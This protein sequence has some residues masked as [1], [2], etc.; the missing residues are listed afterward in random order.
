MTTFTTEDRLA[1]E[2][3]PQV[4]DLYGSPDR[5]FTV[6]ALYSPGEDGDTWI[7]YRDADAR[8][9]CRL[10]AFLA[11]FTPLPQPARSN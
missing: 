2:P 4:G 5:V 10:A 8:Y 7:E 11:R 9:T 6:E 3:K 1:A